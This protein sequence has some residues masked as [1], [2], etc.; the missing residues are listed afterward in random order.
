MNNFYSQ[1]IPLQ[2]TAPVYMPNYK[3]I[4]SQQ[5]EIRSQVKKLLDEDIMQPSVSPY[6]SPIMLVPKKPEDT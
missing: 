4:H 3:S 5:E 2:D 6:N 1:H